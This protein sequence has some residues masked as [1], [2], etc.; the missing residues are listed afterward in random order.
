MICVVS[1]ILSEA[2]YSPHVH[3]HVRDESPHLSASVRIEKEGGGDRSVRLRV[4]L[5][6]V[7]EEEQNF[8]DGYDGHAQRRWPA[9]I[10]VLVGTLDLISA[11]IYRDSSRCRSQVLWR[12]QK[13]DIPVTYT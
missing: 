1:T 13:I 7:R 2:E 10:L 8:D 12:H 11:P 3:E 4:S 6:R 5:D 9:R